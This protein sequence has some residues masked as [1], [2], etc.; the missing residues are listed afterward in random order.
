MK[1]VDKEISSKVQQSLP[2]RECGLKFVDKEISSK[3]QQVAPHAG[4]WIEIFLRCK[5]CDPD[6]VAP[7]AGVWIEIVCPPLHESDNKSLPTREC[8]LK[9]FTSKHFLQNLPVAPHAGVW[10]EIKS[11]RHKN[12]RKNVAPHAGVWIEISRFITSDNM[13]SV[14]PHAGVWIEIFF[15]PFNLII[16]MS[17]PTRECGLKSAHTRKDKSTGSR[18]PRGSVD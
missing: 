10:I 2:T 5:V 8:G 16:H 13:S 3:V 15:P 7:H 11:F 4:V 18:S 17:L 6:C 9:F 12:R 1:F 14:A